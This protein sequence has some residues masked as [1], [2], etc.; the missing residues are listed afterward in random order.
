MSR[1][2]LLETDAISEVL[3][4]LEKDAFT[5]FT[6]FQSKYLKTNSRKYYLLRRSDNVRHIN[7]GGINSVV[8][9]IKNY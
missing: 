6:S 2:S 9:S 5:V 4:K 8:A 7:V 3:S 1:N